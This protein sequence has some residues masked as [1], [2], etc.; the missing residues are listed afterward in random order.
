MQRQAAR[1]EIIPT[2]GSLMFELLTCSFDNLQFSPI[3]CRDV[4]PV[5]KFWCQTLRKST[6]NGFGK[7]QRFISFGLSGIQMNS[8][9]TENDSEIYRLIPYDYKK[10]IPFG[11][12]KRYSSAFPIFLLPSKF[13]TS[14]TIS[15]DIKSFSDVFYLQIFILYMWTPKR[16]DDT[17]PCIQTKQI[18]SCVVAQMLTIY[19]SEEYLGDIE[20]RVDI[21]VTHWEK[22]IHEFVLRTTIP[23]QIKNNVRLLKNHRSKLFIRNETRQT[24]Q[25]ALVISTDHKGATHISN[26]KIIPQTEAAEEEKEEEKKTQPRKRP[27]SE[28]RKKR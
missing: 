17:G 9:N 2:N 27:R 5:C 3:V 26:F 7:I 13:T 19:D 22:S 24:T 28:S 23:H 12:F 18:G 25:S 8:S 4:P 11:G 20:G 1:Q 14:F 15:F 21:C 16:I 6:C 10:C